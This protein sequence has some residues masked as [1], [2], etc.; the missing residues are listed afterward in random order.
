[1]SQER[2]YR[3][4]PADSRRRGLP[5]IGFSLSAPESIELIP[6]E[7]VATTRATL[8]VCRQLG[9]DDRLVGELEIAAFS[10]ALLM[11]RDGILEQMA[12]VE[13]EHALA[14]PAAGRMDA[15]FPVHYGGGASGYR[16]EV[17]LLRDARGV[18]KPPCPYLAFCALACDEIVDAGLFVTIRS[19][20]PEWAAADPILASLRLSRLGGSRRAPANDQ[21]VRLPLLGRR[22]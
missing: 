21:V 1:M 2:E 9:P 14:S 19:A 12:E 3:H 7:P 8:L 4:S 20:A 18:V 16:A 22:R 15:L 17:V 13:A 5:A 11:D 6:S 10:A